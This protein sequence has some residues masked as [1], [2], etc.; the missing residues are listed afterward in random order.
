MKFYQL[1]PEERRQF[2]TESGVTLEDIPAAD[3][4]RLDEMSENVIGEVKFP[5]S[6]LTSALV[7]GKKMADPHDN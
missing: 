3:L 7:N 6:C 2:L 1:P 4:K 5:L